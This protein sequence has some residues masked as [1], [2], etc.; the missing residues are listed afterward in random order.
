MTLKTIV[1]TTLNQ[2]KVK[3][4]KELLKSDKYHIKSLNSFKGVISVEETGKTFEE[5]AI[6]KAHEYGIFCENICIADDSGLAV[7]VLDGA[8]GVYSAR[9]A[10]SDEEKCE[11]LLDLMKNIDESNRTARFI[12]TA[13][14]YMSQNLVTS[15]RRDFAHSND[16]KFFDNVITATGTLEGSIAFEKKGLNGF[17][18]DPI[19]Y[20]PALNKNLAELDSNEKNLISHRGK[21]LKKIKQLLDYM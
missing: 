13:A 18:F 21:A 17:G 14:L 16:Y 8:P 9:F 7:D 11:K 5:N 10:E 6:L 19:F 1:M 15:L 4:F 2:G 20:I 3:E 12:C